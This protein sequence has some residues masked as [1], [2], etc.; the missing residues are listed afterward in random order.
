[1]IRARFVRNA[2]IGTKEGRAQFGDRLLDR[3]SLIAEAL[4]ELPAATQLG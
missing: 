2:E 4:A 1:M 3:V